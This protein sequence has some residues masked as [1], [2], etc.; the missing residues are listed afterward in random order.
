MW[1]KKRITRDMIQAAK[2]Q[3]WNVT[4]TARHYGMHR[5][6]IGAACERFGI[7]L[8]QSKF[9]PQM[10]STTS[11][12]WKENVEKPKPKTPA[13]WSCSPAAVERA[14]AKM[15]HEKRLQATN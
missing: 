6:S 5:T 7:E 4:Q 15:K 1:G 2:E 11:R 10:P 14:L 3:G 9:D 13:I 8:A 12:F